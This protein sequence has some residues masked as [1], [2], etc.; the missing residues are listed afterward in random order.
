[1]EDLIKRLLSGE[2]KLSFLLLEARDF[3]NETENQEFLN[4]INSEVDG[5][6]DDIPSYR[7]IS[8][9]IKAEFTDQMGRKIIQY[10]DLSGLNEQV[11]QVDNTNNIN[12]NESRMYDGIGFIE[13]NLEQLTSGDGMALKPM[14]DG[15][16]ALLSKTLEPGN[17]G[18]KINQIY[19]EVGIAA[20][21]H[22]LTKVREE[23]IKGLQDIKNRKL[24]KTN[25]KNTNDFPKF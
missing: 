13:D 6:K 9:R 17:P 24:K 7:I 20:V 11:N 2:G 21:K 4:F 25:F 1:M 18:I 16:I 15:L 10:L 19:H 8:G 12:F 22:V 3:A 14:P 5:Y 23:T